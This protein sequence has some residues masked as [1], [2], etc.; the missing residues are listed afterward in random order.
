MSSQRP[1]NWRTTAIAF[2]TVAAVAILYRAPAL[3]HARDGLDSD[4][5]AVGLQARHMLQGEWSW[6]VWSAEYQ[7]SFDVILAAI[8][9]R[10]FGQSAIILTCIS[11]AEFLIV[12]WLQFD[13]I[14]RHFGRGAALVCT[15]VLA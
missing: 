4:L 7:G 6:F 5:A 3:I 11:L 10:I 14:R 15:L 9:F 1:S 2:A 8:A 12:V 13:L